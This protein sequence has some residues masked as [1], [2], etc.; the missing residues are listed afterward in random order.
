MG[1][2]FFGGRRNF[3]PQVSYAG[4]TLADYTTGTFSRSSQATN[5]TSATT[6]TVVG[7]NVLRLEDRGDGN[8]P[9]AMF[10]GA[11]TNLVAYSNL[12]GSWTLNGSNTGTSNATTSPD[13]TNNAGNVTKP[14]TPG[15]GPYL[16]LNIG[17]ITEGCISVWAKNNTGGTSTRL[18]FSFATG[19]ALPITLTSGW[20]RYDAYASFTGAANDYI[21]FDHRA[22]VPN[23]GDP[24]ISVA[25][26]Y[27]VYGVQLEAVSKFPS[28]LIPSNS[29]TSGA[30]SA[31]TLTLTTAQYNTA[32]QSVP[33]TF[34]FYPRF[35]NTEC[36]NGDQRWLFSFGG[37][38]DGIYVDTTGG[39]VT[40]VVV[41]GGSIVAQSGALTFS[42]QQKITVTVR[43]ATGALTVSGAT[44][45]NGTVTGTPWTFA[46]STLR[47]GG[48]LSANNEAFC[49]ISQPV[50]V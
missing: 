10:E 9:V 22:D 44:T 23:T 21:S 28:S 38:N 13:G 42:R 39:N 43:P 20:A 48:I 50:G 16:A 49:R 45:G 34:D 14:S 25:T 17:A 19:I 27:Y 18:R 1:L 33:W 40:V 15:T 11:A 7:A 29:G 12:I 26:D 46:N 4:V 6:I 36:T 35:A 37:A 41:A 31:D 47:V 24:A 8:G 5:L 30:R 3:V 32:I 2:P